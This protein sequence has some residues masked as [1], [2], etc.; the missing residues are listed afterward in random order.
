[1]PIRAQGPVVPF[2]RPHAA[3]SPDIHQGPFPD[4]YQQLLYDI[5]DHKT[6]VKRYMFY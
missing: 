4:I 2:R 6:S 1:V 5:R 3:W